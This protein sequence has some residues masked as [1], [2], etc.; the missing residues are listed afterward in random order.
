MRVLQVAPFER[1]AAFGGSQR[2]TSVAERLEERGVEVAWATLPPRVPGRA[3]RMLALASRE[4]AAVQYA[5]RG[6][7][8][9]AGPFDIALAAHSYMA[10]QLARVT[11]ATARV[12]DFH[13]LE[14]RHLDDVAALERPLR[15]A[16]LRVQA[17]RMRR[18]EAGLVR[19]HALSLFASRSELRWARDAGGSGERL[20][21]P[22]L[23]PSAERAVADEAWA[24]RALRRRDDLLLYVGKLTF[25]PNVLS[26]ERFL[27]ETWPPL[28]AAQPGVRLR[29]AGD[30]SEATR[31]RLASFDGVE[32][33]G[34]VEDLRPSLAE[35]GAAV[36]PF[37]GSAGSSLRVLL[38]ALAGLPAIGTAG[39][40]RDF[41]EEL[42]QVV[43]SRDDWIDAV[44]LCL[45]GESA[46]D[47]ARAAALALHE[48]PAP[49]D[50]LYETMRRVIRPAGD[51]EALVSRA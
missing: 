31:A 34:F 33:L 39:A 22:N 36:F 30:C 1:G 17:R 8:P 11:G 43:S 27:R 12:V 14:W 50:A 42:G 16:H 38:F 35:A 48:D 24:E 41:G 28:R 44:R 4:P 29:V 5:R 26:L 7:A 47:R 40:F 13:N 25:P 18:F 9:P 15:R 45:S 3:G 49:W 46:G 23:L 21:V 19:T 2:A 32:V 37:D 10:P 6:D 51:P 20:L